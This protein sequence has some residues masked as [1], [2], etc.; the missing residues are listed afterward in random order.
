[1]MTLLQAAT[2]QMPKTAEAADLLVT[3]ATV[4]S[5]N[6][7]ARHL[8]DKGQLMPRRDGRIAIMAVAADMQTN[9]HGRLGREWM[10]VPG[11]SFTVSFATALP[12]AL[13]T[14]GSV[15]GWIQMTA[16][17]ASLDALR[18]ALEEVGSQSIQPDCQLSLKWPNDV[19]CHGLKLGGILCEL[20][21]LPQDGSADARDYIGVI[22]GIGLNLAVRAERLPTTDSTSLQM[23][24]KGLPDAPIMRDLIAAGIVRSLRARL[25]PLVDDTPT[26]CAALLEEMRAECWTL[27]KQV[28][29]RLAAGGVVSGTAIALNP[30]ASLSVRDD[31]G[32]VHIVRTGDVG[33]LNA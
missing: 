16:G 1:M 19:F 21:P 24:R 22:F 27:G 29:A 14:D 9:G 13:A 33:V 2:P 23:H 28:R 8:I 15:N 30:D 32:E 7:V 31:A 10:N 17:L 11:E 6:S 25:Q 26:Q 4:D 3:R 18:S 12:R 5:T 20:V